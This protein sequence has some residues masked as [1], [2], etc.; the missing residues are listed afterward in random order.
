LDVQDVP[1]REK[2]KLLVS[3]MGTPHLL[4]EDLS[5]PS[6][7]SA[8]KNSLVKSPSSERARRH[9]QLFARARGAVGVISPPCIKD[10]RGDARQLE[11]KLPAGPGVG[12]VSV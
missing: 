4:P 1:A 7:A 3:A 12:S 9:W 2:G 5:E 6:N 10:P 11:S 8:A